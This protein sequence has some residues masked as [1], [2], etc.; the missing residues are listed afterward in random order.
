MRVICGT[1]MYPTVRTPD[2]MAS[3]LLS[4]LE[5]ELSLHPNQSAVASEI[6]ILEAIYGEGAISS[7]KDND[8]TT[9]TLH[10]DVRYQVTTK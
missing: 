8:H 7:W 4:E 3:N 5:A 10:E 9:T 1:S 6:E 2:T